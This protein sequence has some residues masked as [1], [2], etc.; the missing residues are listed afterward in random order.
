MEKAA[1]GLKV[2][3]NPAEIRKQLEEQKVNIF[4]VKSHTYIHVHVYV[5][6]KCTYMYVRMYIQCTCTYVI[7]SF[8]QN[9]GWIQGYI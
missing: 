1:E 5:D 7:Q 6:C 4:T 9:G 3:G 2:D 8:I